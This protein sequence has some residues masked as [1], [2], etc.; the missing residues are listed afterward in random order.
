MMN[1]S[2]K[3]FISG[4]LCA[5]AIILL[6]VP[7]LA[8]EQYPVRTK[9]SSDPRSLR[10]RLSGK[11]LYVR[12]RPCLRQGIRRRCQRGSAALDAEEKRIYRTFG[13]RRQR[14]FL[15]AGMSL[16]QRFFLPVRNVSLRSN[17]QK[18]DRRFQER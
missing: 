16:L 9:E 1:K 15:G 14:G 2:L 18:R 3:G 6:A 8:S 4:V 11:V 17:R 10:A 13:F 12:H 7:A 5:A